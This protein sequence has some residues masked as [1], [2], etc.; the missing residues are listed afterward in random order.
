VGAR[1]W[2]RLLLEQAGLGFR[3]YNSF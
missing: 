2:S 1:T 3:L